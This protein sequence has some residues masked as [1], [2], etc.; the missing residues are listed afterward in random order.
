MRVFFTPTA[1]PY[2]SLVIS[3]SKT[4]P[5]IVQMGNDHTCIHFSDAFIV[6]VFI[7]RFF[8]KSFHRQQW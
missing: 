2:G 6:V 1:V 7:V 5:F 8:D 4:P 3:R